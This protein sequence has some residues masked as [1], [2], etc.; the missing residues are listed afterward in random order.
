MA[1]AGINSDM[2]FIYTVNTMM[3][4]VVFSTV[5]THALRVSVVA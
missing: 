3:C 1:G 2:Y 4:F 5:D